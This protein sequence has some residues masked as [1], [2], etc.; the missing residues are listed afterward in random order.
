MVAPSLNGI[1]SAKVECVTYH[2]PEGGDNE[3]YNSG[4]RSLQRPLLPFMGWMAGVRWCSGKG[5]IRLSP[6]YRLDNQAGLMG[7]AA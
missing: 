4:N 5:S 2:R 3:G 7:V 1:K 6:R